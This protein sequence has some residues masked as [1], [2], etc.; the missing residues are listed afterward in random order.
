MT[1]DHYTQLVDIYNEKKDKGLEVLAF[2]CGQFMNQELASNEEIEEFVEEKFKVTF[3]MFEKIEVNG[4][5]THPIYKYLKFHSKTMNTEKG[6]K[7]I[8]WNF[9]KF[10]VDREGKVVAFYTPKE[11]PND[12]IHA[13]DKLL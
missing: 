2:P 10:L 3:P 12:I 11:K 6:L 9:G 8:P 13:I 7:N 1:S 4:P 5:N